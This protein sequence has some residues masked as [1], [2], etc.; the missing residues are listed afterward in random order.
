MSTPL[1]HAE[2]AARL[3]RFEI[4]HA[5]RACMNRYMVLCDALDTATPLQELAALFTRDA[6]WEGKGARYAK[7]FGG[8]KGR[9]AIQ[10]MFA[11]YMVAPAHFALNVHFLTSELIQVADDC[12]LGSWVM[13]Q[14]S[15]FAS[16]ASHLNA[17][18]LSVR[19]AEEEGQWRMAHFQTENLF[20][21][22]VNSWNSDAPL[23]VPNAQ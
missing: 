22:P 1:T 6:V 8:Y 14:T 21:R 19:F 5:V 7:S 17:A 11:A 15:T 9:E 2:L 13:L 4:E 20:G 16:G 3:E 18:R 23:P 10:Q 12:A